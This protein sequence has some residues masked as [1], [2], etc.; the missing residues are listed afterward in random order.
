[1]LIDSA[2]VEEREDLSE[3]RDQ[4]ERA[5]R[6]A[7]V[8][9]QC[10]RARIH[11]R[12]E[13]QLLR[14]LCRI[15]VGPGGYVQAYVGYAR[16]DADKTIA[17][18]ASA[19][20]EPGYL[21]RKAL[22][23][24]GPRPS[25]C[26]RAIQTGKPYL[27]RDL[28]A[29]PACAHLYTRALEHG[30][31]SMIS[32]PLSVEGRCI[33]GFSIYACEADAFDADE[34]SL[35]T[36]LTDD[37]AYGIAALRREAARGAAE[38]ALRRVERARRVLADCA[39]VLIHAG[40]EEEMLN[41]VCHIF[42]EAVG[43]KQ[44][45][46]GT[47]AAGSSLPLR[48]CA[49]AGYGDAAGPMVTHAK[50][51]EGDHRGLAWE[52]LTTGVT[53]AARNVRTDPAHARKRARALELG[54]GS[55]IAFPLK[56][57][58]Q[59]LGVL[60]LHA[61][62]DDAFDASELAL[63]RDV[64]DEIGYAIDSLRLRAA[65]QQ[66]Q[67]RLLASERRLRETFEQAAVGITRVD[68]EGRIIDVNGKFCQLLGYGKEELV[69]RF[70]K[71]L[72]HPDDYGPGL[73]VREHVARGT[74][75]AMVGKKR[76][77]CKDGGTV[78]TRRTTSVGYD[79]A[80]QSRHII[81]IVEDIS[82]S[83][84]L[85]RRFEL[86]FEQ[87]AVGIALLDLEGRYIQANEAAS[88]MLGYS[89]A[90]LAGMSLFDVL[91]PADVQ[92]AVSE[93]ASLLDGGVESVA[94]LSSYRRRDGGMIRARRVLSIARDTQGKPLHFVAIMEDITASTAAAE[95]Y[96]ATFDHA[97]VGIMH[98][99]ADTEAVLKVNPKL[100]AMLGYS[101]EELLNLNVADIICREDLHAERPKYRQQM[102]DGEIDTYSSERRLARKDGSPLWVYRTISL[103]R[104]A[105]GAPS[106]FIRM[107]E[108]ISERKRAEEAVAVERALLR[109]VVDTI[110]ERI[111][112]KDREGRFRLQNTAYVR[113]HGGAGA[114]DLLGKTV[115]DLFPP[116]V[117]ARLHAEDQAVMESG[118]PIFD[119]ERTAH[120]PDGE[121]RWIASSK[122]PLPDGNG[123]I[124][125]IVGVSRDVTDRKR[126]EQELKQLA[127][128]DAL[129]GL[130]NRA[131]FGARLKEALSYAHTNGWTTGV[132]FIDLDRFKDVNDT[133]G[134]AE[135]DR[136][137]KQAADRLVHAVRRGDSVA[138]LGGDEFAVVLTNLAEGEDAEIVA[139]KIVAS[140][141]EPF[142]LGMREVCVSASIGIS[143]CPIHAQDEDALVRS[144]DAA[145]YEA[146]KAGRNGYRF[147]AR[148]EAPQAPQSSAALH[149]AAA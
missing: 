141:S 80:G 2:T 26:G 139:R 61:A 123:N 58:E 118:V 57:E 11:A 43:Y 110:P 129:T 73:R 105:S 103:V 7:R 68:L 21:E 132:M 48:A 84:A 125:G 108:D 46:I 140:L 142:Q 24:A 44:A 87:A 109:T 102:L 60:V 38:A 9:A 28:L 35:L 135:G 47:P 56:S 131:S 23:W 96:R 149:G 107:M 8:F 55:S 136:L 33:G 115:F 36:A 50:A 95:T 72:T 97:P 75:G 111:Y 19:G 52:A 69:G 51:I 85:E 148:A 82:E 126:I 27:T 45:W 104:D 112:A 79:D 17:P 122:V 10:S 18:V 146:K 31:Q 145:M 70:V 1:V 41:R 77:L 94:S 34:V 20:F 100:C 63:L 40:A 29:D 67:A 12:D 93:I 14:E 5:T 25:L 78:W 3:G 133:L 6:A 98:N 16:D 137:L 74:G 124:I 39:R 66:A 42:V 119:R 59:V 138:R 83:K 127:H 54:Y 106:Y 143:L 114:G 32:L 128:F 116:E 99:A 22:T 101:E 15:V 121:P 144:A 86:I 49:Q 30:F 88:E 13:A 117:A 37:I 130:P 71:D 89:T 64:A 53:Q 76:Y 65:H 92:A 134:H 4:L 120:G 62:E 90:E 81:S 147:H 113:T 91:L